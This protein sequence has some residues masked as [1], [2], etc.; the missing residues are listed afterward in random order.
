MELIVETRKIFGKKVRF[1]RRQGITPAHLYGHNVEPVPLQCDTVHLRQVLAKT[2]TTGLIELKLDKARKTRAVMTREIQK[3][4][5]TGE[6][7]HVDFY[8]V[9]MEEKIRVE[10]PIVQVG[11]APA[12]KMKE[13]FLSH[14]LDTLSIECLPNEIPAQIEL[15][16]SVLEEAD[17]TIHVSD[18]V[19]GDNI[20][21]LT[22]PEQ[23]I[24]KISTGFV[25][26]EGPEGELGLEAV[27]AEGVGAPE[28]KPEEAASSED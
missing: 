21:V 10:V 4:A 20:T 5:L 1:L 25:E 16:V 28:E 17:Q 27:S 23:L 7:I 13:N 9:R 8:Q 14:E 12:L 24:M 11:E 19:L 3:D 26:K 18:I 22:N 6:L 15:D 2:G